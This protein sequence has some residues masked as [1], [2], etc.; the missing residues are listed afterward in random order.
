MQ[1]RSSFQET[2]GSFPILLRNILDPLFN[3]LGVL[4]L[5]VSVEGAGKREILGVHRSDVSLLDSHRRL[6][7]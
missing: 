5:H 6:V 7:S 1:S 3:Y 4:E 2:D